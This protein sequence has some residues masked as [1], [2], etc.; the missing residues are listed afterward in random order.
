MFRTDIK[1]T[2][3][4]GA[5]LP[6]VEDENED[7]EPD[8]KRTAGIWK[9][10]PRLPVWQRDSFK[11]VFKALQKSRQEIAESL[12][13]RKLLFFET[14]PMNFGNYHCEGDATV[15][16]GES[17]WATITDQILDAKLNLKDLKGALDKIF[18]I[19]EYEKLV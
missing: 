7:S 9:I 16:E 19:S 11:H 10:K 1:H 3:F 8:T 5:S 12:G 15:E 17:K 13:S 2:R 4:A 18:E 14:K 6:P